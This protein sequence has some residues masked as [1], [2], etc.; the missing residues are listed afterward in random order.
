M[1]DTRPFF[2][3]EPFLDALISGVVSQH[4]RQK[5]F[6]EREPFFDALICLVVFPSN[7]KLKTP[8]G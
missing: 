1:N 4:E 5:P 3:R 7:Q 8:R 2:K 6:Y